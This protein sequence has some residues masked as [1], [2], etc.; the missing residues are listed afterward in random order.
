MTESG[1]RTAVDLV[2]GF[3]ATWATNE[4]LK[5]AADTGVVWR[6]AEVFLIVMSFFTTA[7]AVIKR[8]LWPVQN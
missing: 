8:K 6:E 5:R 1:A 4:I 3:A 7:S 2:I